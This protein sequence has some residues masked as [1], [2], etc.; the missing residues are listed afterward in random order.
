[1]IIRE[2]YLNQLIETKDLNLIKVITGVRRSGKSTLL[3]QFKDYLTNSG[4]DKNN[5]IYMSFESAEWYD[6]KNYRDLYNYIK[7]KYNGTKL[8]L[9][10]DEVQNIGEWEKAVNSFLVDIDADIYVTGSNANLLSSELTTLLA[11]RVYTVQIYPLSFAE[12]IQIYPFKNNEDKYKMFDKYL[13]F[14]GMPMLASLNDNERLMVNYLSD[15]KDVVLKKD[16]IA[17]NKIKDIVF[18][19]NLLQYMSTVIGTLI[20]PSS[21]AEFMK[22]NGSSIDNETVDKYLKMIENAYFIYR[23][24]RY[25]LKG[26]QLLKTQGKYYFVDNGL[27]NI[28][29]G[30]SS[31]DS[32]NSYENIVC[33]ELLRRGYEVYV[34]KYNDL[35]I[36]FIAISP[37]EKIYYQVARSI[38]S[39]EVENREKRSLLAI[40][41]NYKKVILTMDNAYNKVIDGIEVVNIVDFLLEEK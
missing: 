6:I 3:L 9:L 31:Y 41:D 2:K 36:D 35:E 38:L 32:G 20:N 28:L 40:D 13:K 34:G 33:M 21:I 25:E 22:K 14:G 5:I 17:R 39:E 11:G 8:Y 27:K 29:S 4:I 12:Y 10:L 7:S 37:E 16:I 24:P 1:M 30:F 26:K 18:L 19:D 23:I 15:I